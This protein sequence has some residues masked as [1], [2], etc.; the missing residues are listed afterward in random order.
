MNPQSPYYESELFQQ[1]LQFGASEGPFMGLSFK[2]TN[3]A[4][5]MAK[6]GISGLDEVIALLGNIQTAVFPEMTKSWAREKNK[7]YICLEK[8]F[9]S[10]YCCFFV[11][12]PA[13]FSW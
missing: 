8:E 10:Q 12:P 5:L 6:D 4:F 1:I 2:K 13:R 3:D 9:L 7:L 11:N